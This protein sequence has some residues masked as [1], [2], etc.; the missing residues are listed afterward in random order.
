LD[1]E[2]PV[3]AGNR[4]DISLHLLVKNGESVVGRLLDCVGPYLAEVVAVLNDCEDGTGSVLIQKAA[5]HGLRR[6]E[7][8]EVTHA[9]HPDL[10][11]LD[12]PETYLEGRPLVGESLP[13]VHTGGPLLADFAAARNL[14][15]V[16]CIG[17]WRLFLDAD[18]VVDDPGC[19]PALCSALEARGIDGA[20]SR[21]HHGGGCGSRERLARNLPA[22]RWEGAVH[23]RLVG[24]QVGR[25]A[26]VEDCL[27]VRDLLDSRGA[28]TRSPGRNLK[29][30]YHQARSLDWKITPRDMAYLASESAQAMPELSR[31]L[32]EDCAER[33]GWPAERAWACSTRGQVAEDEGRHDQATAWYR[34]SLHEH[35]S[36]A[37][38]LHLARAC[39]QLGQWG[40]VL[41]A[42]DQARS[43]L[44]GASQ[45]I[46][47]GE[48]DADAVETLV[49]AALLELG[50][51]DE[52]EDRCGRLLSRHPGS[53]ALRS[54]RERIDR[55]AGRSI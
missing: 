44:A 27:V 40:E 16:R 14:G 25:T 15:W 18:D 3:T 51:L 26:H 37:A 48:V 47:A 39:F 54:M 5:E 23:E 28:G 22:V 55:V 46:D 50:R 24:F 52:A 32:A 1:Q 2:G 33:S 6:C 4:P 7:L 35:P 13:D 8:V 30:L 19:L 42:H 11:L 17:D 12:V 45:P 29:V 41:A 43:I 9:S 34:R 53:R 10:Y 36:S 21:Y 31:R 38:A 20:S 49:V